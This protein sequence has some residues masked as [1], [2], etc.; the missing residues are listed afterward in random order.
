MLINYLK[1][2]KT[3]ADSIPVV[4]VMDAPAVMPKAE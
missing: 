2:E 4:P 1:V 3:P